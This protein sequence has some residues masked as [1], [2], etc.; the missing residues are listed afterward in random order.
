MTPRRILHIITRLILGGAQQNTILSCAGQI[1]LGHEAWLAYG[2]I[3]GPEGSL[4]DRAVASKANLVELRSMRRAI[5]PVHDVVCYRALRKL[6]RKVKPDVVHTHS[7]KAGIVGRAAAWAERVPAVIHTIHG[8]P[9][10]ERQPRVVHRAY[11]AA[12]RW[13]A[14]RCHHICGVTQA[15]GDAFVEQ[16]ILPDLS[17][18]TLVPS[19]VDVASFSFDEAVRTRVRQE[20]GIPMAAPVVGLVARL[21]PL[22]GQDDLIDIFPRLL[23]SHPDARL[24]FVG[25]G[26]HRQKL[27]PRLK[28]MAE[29][30][31]SQVIFT[32]LVPPARVVELLCAMDINTL[33]SY[34]EGQPRTLV[35]ALLCE[36]PV[37]GYDAGGIREICV[38]GKTG[39][40]V[41]TIGDRDGLLDAVRWMLDHPEERETMGRFGR[42]YAMERFASQIMVRQL[43]SIYE[44]VLAAKNGGGADDGVT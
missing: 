33:P 6:I 16:G 32:G 22:K 26:W 37:V 17:R 1:E 35:Q 23:E 15:M 12:E 25:D 2:P 27:D 3:Y 42:A 31:A 4:L 44:Q 28:A 19:G 38:D 7:S 8:L 9:F 40:L 14:K 18:F 29:A 24:L 34:Q 5:L 43:D 39:R 41:K 10:H 20:L 21:D 13:A 36:R 11:V 30:H